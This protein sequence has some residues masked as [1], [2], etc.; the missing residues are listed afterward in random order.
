MIKWLRKLNAKV[1]G[2]ALPPYTTPSHFEVGEVQNDLAQN[3]FGDLR[4]LSLLSK[5]IDEFHPD[6]IMHLGAQSIVSRGYSDPIETFSTN[7]MGT[8]NVLES[9]R[10]ANRPCAILCVTSDKCYEN[11]E[12]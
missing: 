11:K 6:L 5:S 9:V 2:F 10:L 1:C 4:D 3:I 8:A 7:V 12:Q